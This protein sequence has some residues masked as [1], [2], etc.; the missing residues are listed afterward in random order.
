M[1]DLGLPHRAIREQLERGV[2]LVVHMERAADGSRRVAE[3]AE[4]G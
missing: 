1:A 3:I 4:V 2:D